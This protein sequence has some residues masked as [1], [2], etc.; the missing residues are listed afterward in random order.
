MPW[1]SRISDMFIVMMEMW[2]VNSSFEIKKTFFSLL[3]NHKFRLWNS[4][5]VLVQNLWLPSFLSWFELKHA[6]PPRF[7][8]YFMID[9]DFRLVIVS[10]NTKSS[11]V[12]FS[13]CAQGF[14]WVADLRIMERALREPPLP[15]TH[16]PSPPSLHLFPFTSILRR[17]N[18]GQERWTRRLSSSRA[19]PRESAWPWPSA[20]QGMRRKGSWV[21][22]REGSV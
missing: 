5:K 17:P 12:I 13:P 11:V 1:N 3:C 7:L 20:S 22:E 9:C 18:T 15:H 14:C 2:R 8:P 21:S 10:L 16:C 19:A 4:N 6:F